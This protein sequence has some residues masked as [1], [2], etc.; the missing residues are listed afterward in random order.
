MMIINPF[1][2]KPAHIIP[3]YVKI[4]MPL[5][6]VDGF[7]DI[8]NNHAITVVGSPTIT[9]TNSKFGAGSLRVTIG[10][11]LR[12]DSTP[13]LD[14]SGKK[15]FTFEFWVYLTSSHSTTS[16]ILSMRN[17]G[18]YCPFVIKE[19]IVFLGDNS[20]SGWVY[21]MA[22]GASVGRETWSHVA[23]VFDGTN[24]KLYINGTLSNPATAVK[25][26]PSWP[27]GDRFLNIGYD[28][29]GFMDGYI[30]DLRISDTAVYTGDFTPPTSPF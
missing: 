14:M 15:P 22:S 7:T 24:V 9:T 5:N 27:T 23:L 2:N 19:T 20:L 17:G 28:V 26:Y 16:G 3:P 21:Y 12:I 11:H 10:N 25:P 1:I 29:N 6:S 30:N 13:T 4:L 8:A 18:E